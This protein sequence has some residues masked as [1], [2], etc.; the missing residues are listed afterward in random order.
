MTKFK[1]LLTLEEEDEDRDAGEKDED[2]TK[3]EDTGNE[4]SD[5]VNNT[6]TQDLKLKS[7]KLNKKQ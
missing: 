3:I 1:D 4:L 6:K 7:K 5:R 2:E